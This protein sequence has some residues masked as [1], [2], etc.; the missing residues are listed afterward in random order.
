MLVPPLSAPRLER[1]VAHAR[2]LGRADEPALVDLE[3]TLRGRHRALTLGLMRRF[4][5]TERLRAAWRRGDLGQRWRL[6]KATLKIPDAATTARYLALEDMP[7]GT[8]GRRFLEHCRRHGFALPGERRAL[9]EPLV[10]HDMG[11]ALIGADTDVPGETVMAGFEAGCMGEG[12]FTM[13]EFTLLLFNLGARL[14]T[15]AKPEVGKV[16]IGLR[17][18]RCASDQR[19]VIGRADFRPGLAARLDELATDEISCEFGH[20]ELQPRRSFMLG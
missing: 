1:L 12:G 8:L 13:L 19:A 11:H 7:E 6:I 17:G 16:D 3:R 15:D 4:P 5:P 20:V 18:Q 9:A 14:P 2:A 10:F